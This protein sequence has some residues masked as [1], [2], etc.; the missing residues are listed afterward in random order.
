MTAP[1]G[2]LE[3]INVSRGGVP[4]HTVPEVLIT[5]SGVEGDAQRDLRYHGGPD[6]AVIL[7]SLDVIRALQREGH[8]IA[9]GTTGENLTV[10]GLHWPEL[11][12]GTEI[13]VGGVQLRVTSYASPC[14]HI[15]HSFLDKQY[16]RIAQARHPGWSR[17]CARVL[18]A[19]LVR[20]GDSVLLRP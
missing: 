13:V 18:E 10:S 19:G 15:R 14:S 17:L 11:G 2:R 1:A 12:P 16:M 4:K 3:S 5:E 8:A 7:F 9:P 20:L 6:R